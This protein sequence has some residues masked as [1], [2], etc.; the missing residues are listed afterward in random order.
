MLSKGSHVRDEAINECSFSKHLEIFHVDTSDDLETVLAFCHGNFPNLTQLSLEYRTVASLSPSAIKRAFP[1]LS[2]LTMRNVEPDS[3][4]TFPWHHASSNAIGYFRATVFTF[5]R[6][7]ATDNQLG[8]SFVLTGIIHEVVINGLKNLDSAILSNVTG[9]RSL[10]LALN[11]LT[12]VPKYVFEN[13]F[14]MTRLVF[15]FNQINNVDNDPFDSLSQLQYLDLSYNK[16]RMLPANVFDHLTSLK[17]IHLEGNYLHG[18]PYQLFRYQFSTIKAIFIYSNPLEDIPVI[19]I[20]APNLYVYDLHNTSINDESLLGLSRVLDVPDWTLGNVQRQIDF[21]TTDYDFCKKRIDMSFCNISSFPSPD[22]ASNTGR[23]GLAYLLYNAIELKGNPLHCGC[24]LL[25]LHQ[26]IDS[27]GTTHADITTRAKQWVCF[28]PTDLRGREVLTITRSEMLC[29]VNVSHC[30]F[31]CSCSV[32]RDF[33]S[34]VVDCRNS[35]MQKLPMKMPSFKSYIE[36]DILFR[37]SNI[38]TLSK[39]GYF[40]RVRILDVSSCK[41]QSIEYF[42]FS[43]FEH[44]EELRLD[45]NLLSTLPKA[46]MSITNVKLITLS[47]NPF[48]CDCRLSWMKGWLLRSDSPVIDGQSV[49]CTDGSEKGNVLLGVD[50][51]LFACN[52]EIFVNL[53]HVIMPS[54]IVGLLC[55]ISSVVMLVVYIQRLRVKVLL[56]IYCGLKP[57]DSDKT[58]RIYQFDASVIYSSSDREFIKE[59][60]LDYLTE[61]G[62]AVADMY[63]DFFIGKSFTANIHH[64]VNNSRRLIL[65]VSNIP[66][67]NDL[68]RTSWNIAYEKTVQSHS[69]FL[70]LILNNKRV[71]KCTETSFSRYVK[72]GRFVQ[73]DTVLFHESLYYLMPKPTN[74]YDT[75]E[76]R[77]ELVD[78]M[79]VSGRPCER[80]PYTFVTYPDDI[81]TSVTNTLIPKL[82]E[83]G[84]TVRNFEMEFTPGASKDEEIIKYID[85][86]RHLIYIMSEATLLDEWKTIILKHAIA[87][88]MTSDHNYLLLFTHGEIREESLTSEIWQ[89]MNTYVTM[90]MEDEEFLRML[91]KALSAVTGERRSVLAEESSSAEMDTPLV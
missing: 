45:S 77:Q 38:D 74:P 16:L 66:F 68:L 62:Y 28:T 36:L 78:V 81:H 59:H 87:K 54:I 73:K 7:T 42:V 11:Y 61:K 37:G 50:D 19:P 83:N 33:S 80:E 23:L 18:M 75:S 21:E 63:R 14:N 12:Q 72:N 46:I 2:D 47:N 90:R 82:H 17:E 10:D 31:S 60:V 1:K 13:Q 15:R 39:R 56:Y 6:T 5:I 53:R 24:S 71:P 35:S 65:S 84:H 70:I 91:L 49:K 30:P 29:P 58:D 4:L 8:A 86:S 55:F 51:Y 48:L 76:T 69:N 9:L 27:M 89:Y 41:L 3:T 79:L 85:S 57:F 22:D 34:L 32:R 20:Y 43:Q 40:N 25:Y 26:L 88:T 44:L 64:F 52:D 67:E